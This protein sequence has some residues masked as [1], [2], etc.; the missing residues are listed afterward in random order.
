[1]GNREVIEEDVE[2]KLGTTYIM[3]YDNLTLTLLRLDMQSHESAIPQSRGKA[4]HQTQSHGIH[5]L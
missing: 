1:M 5:E 2:E 4:D 3:I